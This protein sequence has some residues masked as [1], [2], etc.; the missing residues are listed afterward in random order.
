MN[1]NQIEKL[2]KVLEEIMATLNYQPE[3]PMQHKVDILNAYTDFKRSFNSPPAED[4]IK[5]PNLT[6]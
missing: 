2:Q 4:L 5:E 1:A 3:I 6:L